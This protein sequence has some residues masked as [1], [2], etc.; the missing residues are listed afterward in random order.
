MGLS[1]PVSCRLPTGF[2]LDSHLLQLIVLRYADE[3]LQLGFDDFLNCLVRL[4][5]A[6]RECL[7]GLRGAVAGLRPGCGRAAVGL[8]VL[9]G[10]VTS[11]ATFQECVRHNLAK[12]WPRQA[13]R[14]CWICVTRVVA[15]GR[16]CVHLLGTAL[17]IT[18]R[19]L[20]AG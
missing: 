18:P 5:N 14:V 9:P 11:P 2:Q 4:E 13:Q 17:V 16:E 1:H 7:V 20:V 8:H 3:G 10:R 19:I 12:L 15:E 6:S